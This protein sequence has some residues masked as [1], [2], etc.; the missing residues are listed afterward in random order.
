MAQD[1]FQKNKEPSIYD[2]VMLF[3]MLD[4]GRTGMISA[5]NLRNFL[6]TAHRMKEA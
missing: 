5:R 2:F 4:E 6:E 1:L 3:E